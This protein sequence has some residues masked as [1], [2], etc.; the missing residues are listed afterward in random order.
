LDIVALARPVPQ[1]GRDPRRERR[2]GTAERDRR[3]PA[4]ARAAGRAVGRSTSPDRGR[5][6]SA[7]RAARRGGATGRAIA[8]IGETF[9]SKLDSTSLVELAVRTAAEACRADLGRAVVGERV[10]QIGRSDRRL[11]RA[12]AIAR[13]AVRRQGRGTAVACDDGAAL[14]HPLPDG[15]VLAI[16]R[17]RAPFSEDD[18]RRFG[19]LVR[20]LGVAIENAA[21]HEQL[22]QQATTDELTGLANHRRFEE[23]LRQEV[24]R[25]ARS[26]RPLALVMVDIDNFKH[27]ND[28]H[29]HQQGD[30]VLREVAA[31]LH[32]TS[33]A[34]DVPARYGG[35]ELPSSCPTPTSRAA[36]SR[37]RR[38]GARRAHSSFR[39]RAEA[40]S[41]S[42]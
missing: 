21:L 23:R 10:I 5:G 42:P 11:G 25:S 33:R 9:A 32:R 19:S 15:T 34:T 22:R 36:V 30:L 29:G 38:S 2:H 18:Q 1:P 12:L 39:C 4:A 26:G 31:A 16:A 28:T 3:G 40:R 6:E 41:P 27:V 14:S 8:R 7:R 37:P 35:E 17:A 20:Q 24:R 13:E